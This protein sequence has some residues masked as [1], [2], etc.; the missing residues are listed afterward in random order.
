MRS[1]CVSHVIQ[2]LTLVLIV[3]TPIGTSTDGNVAELRIGVAQAGAGYAI[4]TVPLEEYVAR[5]L[6][7]EALPDSQP[8]AL[9][10]LAI[11]I[12]TY[13]LANR[14]RHNTDGF[15]LCD[16]TH[17]QVMRTASPATERAAAATAGRVLLNGGAPASVFYSASCGGRTE[18]PSAV[19]PGERDRSFLPT[20]DDD[21]CRGAP[22][23]AA[24]LAANDLLRSFRAGGFSGDRLNDVKIIERNS[25]GRVARLRL[26]GLQPSEISGQNLRVVV[27]RT[28]GWQH[29]KSTAFDLTRTP[30][31][32]RFRG[33]GSGHGVG[34]CVIG[35]ARRAEAG[36]SADDILHR[37][38]PGL[39]IA[40]PNEAVST[41]RRVTAP[42]APDSRVSRASPTTAPVNVAPDVSVALPAGD[43]AERSDIVDIVARSRDD[44]SRTLGVAAPRVTFRFH[45]SAESYERATAQ[46]WFTSGAVVNGSIHLLSPAALRAR[47]VLER[48]IRHEL[49]HVMTNEALSGRPLWV[50]E[51]AA[52]YFAGETAVPTGRPDVRAST[53]TPRV[54]CPSDADLLRPASAGALTDAYARARVCFER[55]MTHAKSWR[56]VR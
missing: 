12:R 34:L 18:L 1:C 25:S 56:D 11:T 35:S 52:I 13:A 6:T 46:P 50:Q 39:A 33:H 15:D 22:A 29:I 2:V 40:V 37:Y 47:G 38:F 49:V 24:E 32:Y 9:E 17:C 44:L 27:G 26:E 16:E 42:A 30:N 31:G 28:L 20:Q 53:P 14:N 4:T 23:W 7:G 51:G 5:V 54:P 41:A 43:E 48:T 8:A 3:A 45:E 21:A 36:E 19:W 55:E 10:A